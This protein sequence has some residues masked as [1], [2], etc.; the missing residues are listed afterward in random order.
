MWFPIGPDFVNQP[1]DLVRTRLSRRNQQGHQGAVAWIAAGAPPTRSIYIVVKPSTPGVSSGTLF[2]SDDQGV[3]WVPCWDGQLRASGG[4]TGS[5]A[6]MT[7]HPNIDG[8]VYVVAGGK[9]FTSADWGGTWDAGQ[10]FGR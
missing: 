2:R 10:T 3:T 6:A 4:F 5:V 7:A 8:T 9:L 1:F